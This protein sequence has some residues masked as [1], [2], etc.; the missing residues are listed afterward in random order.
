MKKV[1]EYNTDSN[2]YKISI[3]TDKKSIA[4]LEDNNGDKVKWD[5]KI[6]SLPSILTK[7]NTISQDISKRRLY[8]DIIYSALEKENIDIY[9][10]ESTYFSNIQNSLFLQINNNVWLVA[11]YSKDNALWIKGR[12]YNTPFVWKPYEYS[13]TAVYVESL[14]H[15]DGTG[16]VFTPTLVFD[17]IISAGYKTLNSFIEHIK[18]TAVDLNKYNDFLTGFETTKNIP[19][20]EINDPFVNNSPVKAVDKADNK[21][22]NA[23]S[24]ELKGVINICDINIKTDIDIPDAPKKKRK[25]ILDI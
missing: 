14:W 9:E 17:R 22:S 23:I 15:D 3:D 1:F 11:Y 25:N 12:I 8:R 19:T 6:K 24:D 4:M 7:K 5:Y 13:T 21:N 20:V 16:A 18:N 2:C 10:I